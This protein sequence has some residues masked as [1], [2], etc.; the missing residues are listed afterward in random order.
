LELTII[1][2]KLNVYQLNQIYLKL[3]EALN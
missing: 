2:Y 3:S 1:D